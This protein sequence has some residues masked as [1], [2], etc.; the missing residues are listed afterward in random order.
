MSTRI[1][2]LKIANSLKNDIG[3]Y[4]CLA[5]NIAGQANT[6][7]KLFLDLE[8]NVDETPI[9]NP[10]AFKNLEQPLFPI[11][12]GKEDTPESSA[13]LVP[14]HVI[15][16]LNDTRIKQGDSLLLVCKIDGY[17]KPEVFIY[18][19]LIFFFVR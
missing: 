7:C 1:G 16:P 15:V 14:P 13:K 5:Q 6:S 4:T 17:P 19:L 2:T 9:V 3:D 11:N 12:D 8:P 10:E 18:K